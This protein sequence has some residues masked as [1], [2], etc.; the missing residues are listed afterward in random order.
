MAAVAPSAEKAAD[1]L[2]NLSIESQAKTLEIP[3]PTKKASSYPYGGVDSGVAANG[4]IQPSD[5]SL[6]P[7]LPDIMDP[8]LCYLP[9]GYPSPAYY[10][11]GYNGTGADWEDYGRYNTEGVD[12]T[13]GVYGDNSSVMYHNAYGYAPYGP[14]SPATSP[15]PTL[16]ND[17]QLYGPQHYQ[18]PPY[19]QPLNPTSGPFTPSQATNPQGEPC[20]SVGTDQKPLPVETA[21]VS[22][23]G[24]AN[25]GGMKG[26][27][28]S[29]PY[30][31]MYQN[32]SLNTYGRGVLPGALPGSGY[33]DPR[34]G[35]DGQYRNTGM[36]PFSKGNNV[37]SSKNN[38]YRQSSNYMQ[39]GPM[40]G[41]G[42]TQGFMNRMYPSKFYGHYGNTF[43]SG[44]G[45]GAGGYD[46]RVNPNGWLAVDSKYKPR[47]RG[48]GY[49]GYRNESV[50]GLNELNR[51]P[52]AKGFK[53]QKGFAPV[54]I[55]VKGQNTPLVETI[56]EEKE[57]MSAIPD[58]EQYNTADFAEEYTEAKFFIIKSYS[59]DDVH[60]SIKY[61][62]WA[63][64]PN[65]NK[66]LD[67]AYLE[68]QQKSG[69]CPIFLFFSVNT[70]GQFVGLAEMVG[71][72]DF[73]K[74]VEYWQQD[75][76][77]G[78]FPVKWH[79]VKDIPNSLLKHITL[80]NNENKP[81]TNS[82]DTQ[83]VKLEQG[84][85]MV[86]I[87][88]DHSNKTCILDDFGFYEKRQKIIQEKKA[89]QQQFQKQATEGKPIDEKKDLV[90]GSLESVDVAPEVTKEPAPV[91]QSNGDVKPLENGSVV[92]SVDDSKAASKPVASPV[93]T[94][95]K[96]ITSNGIVANG[97]ANGC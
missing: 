66:K 58:R 74:N 25:G 29:T 22:S 52:R 48:N 60:K 63:S 88:K 34:L 24:I 76:W 9:N 47:G 14:Y 40:S 65:G 16:G 94:P 72:V 36:T 51:G 75:K 56:S 42:N 69:G 55:A 82:R 61:N 23:T 84:L 17:G 32:S 62:V 18:Y 73:H 78:C 20:T 44:M 26:N 81:V 10:Y 91:I 89:K 8:T 87:F 45:F 49:F 50:D 7:F 5:R 95:E 93:A 11:G 6:T 77:T 33:Q 70:S 92:K 35:Y 3:E 28:G 1:L 4:Q 96:R 43:R 97:I 90:N 39:S 37:P 86:K 67:A 85:K 59:E 15:V 54:T 41:M 30:K 27:N 83:E 79:I 46:S 13:P 31:P 53:T 64:T 12:M 19:F 80:E 57:D 38:N 21:K 2:Q 71:P 68:A